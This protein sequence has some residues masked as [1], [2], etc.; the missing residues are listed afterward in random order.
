MYEVDAVFLCWFFQVL[1]F[2][3]VVELCG[4]GLLEDPSSIGANVWYKSEIPGP[5]LQLSDHSAGC[6]KVLK[7]GGTGSRQ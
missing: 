1:C 7:P 5:Q 4:T 2:V 3:F 6:G